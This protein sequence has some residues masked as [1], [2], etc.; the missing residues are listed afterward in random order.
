MLF[1]CFQISKYIFVDI[2]SGSRRIGSRYQWPAVHHVNY[3]PS[4]TFYVKN[5]VGKVAWGQIS[6]QVLQFL[7]S[8]IVPPLLRTHA[9][10]SSIEAM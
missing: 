10:S 5:A 7:L 3:G 4:R 9:F 2:I 1:S 8:D 6:F